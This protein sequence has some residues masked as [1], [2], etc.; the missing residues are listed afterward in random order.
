VFCRFGRC[1][2]CSDDGIGMRFY[3]KWIF[4]LGVRVCCIWRYIGDVG[5]I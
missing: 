4:V 5:R 3:R 1:A 2:R